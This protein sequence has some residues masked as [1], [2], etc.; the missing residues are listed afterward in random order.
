MTTPTGNP[1]N[2]ITLDTQSDPINMSAPIDAEAGIIYLTL[3]PTNILAIWGETSPTNPIV[4]VKQ[5]TIAVTND[6]RI[7]T[8]ILNEL[9]FTPKLL[10]VL[11]PDDNALRDL[12]V[13]SDPIEI[14]NMAI[15][16]YGKISQL[17]FP[18]EPSDHS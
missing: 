5:T 14:M 18:N 3:E 6:I 7:R 4:P 2:P 11:S 13:N 8:E 9:G 16:I 15:K 17:D 12:A 10:A 1:D